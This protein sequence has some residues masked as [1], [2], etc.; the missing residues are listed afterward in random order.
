MNSK[1][2]LP[3]IYGDLSKIVKQTKLFKKNGYSRNY[4]SDFLKAPDKSKIPI[5]AQEIILAA[6]E[7]VVQDRNIKAKS[8]KKRVK[9]LS[10]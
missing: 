8:I 10:S 3:L 1:Q 4:C 9:A 2:Q 7:K 6:Y 5:E